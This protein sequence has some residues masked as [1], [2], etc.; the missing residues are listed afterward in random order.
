[1]GA[2]NGSGSQN[3]IVLWY[4][5]FVLDLIVNTLIVGEK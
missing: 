1:M 4:S 3:L 2:F 5:V